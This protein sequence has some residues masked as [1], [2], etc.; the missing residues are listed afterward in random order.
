MVIDPC[1][2]G[3]TELSKR[4]GNPIATFQ[5]GDG[6]FDFEGQKVSVDSGI[7]HVYK[8]SENEDLHLQGDLA[9]NPFA[10]VAYLERC[11]TQEEVKQAIE[12][13]DK[14]YEFEN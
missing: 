8:V 1:Y 4:Y 7:I 13:Y 5:T 6:V 14:Y 10:E 2:L 12:Y 3:E 11:P 9:D